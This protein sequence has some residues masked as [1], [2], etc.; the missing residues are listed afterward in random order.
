[1]DQE[2]EQE[3]KQREDT[4]IYVLDGIGRV[5]IILVVV[6]S[7]LSILNIPIGPVLASFGI[8]GVAVGFGAQ[9]LI[10]DLIAGIF[11]IMENQYRVGDVVKISDVSGLVQQINLRKT[12]LRDMDGVVHHIPNGE[13]K[14]ASNLTRNFSRVN[15]NI[16]VSYNTELGRAIKIINQVG[17]NMAKE[18]KW[19]CLIITPPKALR[20]DELGDSGIEIKV[21]GDVQPG[22]QWDM[23]GELRLRI[24]NAFDAEGIEMPWPHTKVYFGNQPQTVNG[25]SCGMCSNVNIPGSKYCAKCGNILK[26]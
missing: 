4:L 8:A 19:R 5:I 10:R 24:K 17:E 7:I 6:F 11:I 14:V 13:I 3:E 12:V 23:M 9:Y 25:V 20:V 18:E 16:S 1:M 22:A 2:T 26:T 21:T 15:L